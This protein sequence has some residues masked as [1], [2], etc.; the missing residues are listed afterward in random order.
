[1]MGPYLTMSFNTTK[2]DR[3]KGFNP[4]KRDDGSVLQ[5]VGVPAVKYNTKRQGVA[6][7]QALPPTCAGSARLATIS[8][9]EIYGGIVA[10]SVKKGSKT[11][12]FKAKN[13]HLWGVGPETW[14]R[15]QKRVYPPGIVAKMLLGG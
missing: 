14:R 4:V 15:S 9:T 13:P 2:E 12:C 8:N 11:G 6:P 3:A 5:W 10:K 7:R 1:M